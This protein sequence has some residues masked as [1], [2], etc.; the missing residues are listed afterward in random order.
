MN[1]VLICLALFAVVDL[2][3]AEVYLTTCARMDVPIAKKFAKA[4]CVASCSSQN[5]A[6]G[7]CKISKGRKTCICRR[8]ANGG[9]FPL[10]ALIGLAKKGRK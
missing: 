3:L 8:C 10:D 5:C 1:R 4:A 2:A 9:N 7:D 6:T